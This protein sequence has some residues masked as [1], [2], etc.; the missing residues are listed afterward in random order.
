MH[1]KISLYDIISI[2]LLALISITFLFPLYRTLMTSFSDPDKLGFK[3]VY[4]LPFGFSTEA[5]NYLLNNPMVF[6]YYFNSILYAC[7]SSL[8]MV[9]VTSTMAY[10]LMIPGFRGKMLVSNCLILTIYF[11]GGLIS[12]YIV[13][14]IILHMKNTIWP[15]VFLGTLS[16][17]TVIIFRSF[18][19]E[20]PQSLT[21]AAQI[22]G[23]RHFWILFRIILPL[24]TPLIAT[25]VLFRAVGSWNDYFTPMIYVSSD[26]QYP[27]QIRLRRLVV[28]MQISDLRYQT[29][30]MQYSK[31]TPRTVQAAAI[32][33]T[34]TP[35]MCVYPFLQKYFTKGMI[36][37]A[38]KA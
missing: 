6:H 20:I 26:S 25:F 1:R 36:I 8:C 22:D 11:G 30:L 12:T 4:L 28:L 23:A 24:S 35:I 9:F 15:M 3:S 18:F 33:I 14:G 16:P 13:V 27:I 2:V 31:I 19:Q 7:L 17:I 29:L 5:Y 32:I 21:E 37:G 10:P 38:V 34:M